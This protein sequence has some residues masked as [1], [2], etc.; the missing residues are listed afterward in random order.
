MSLRRKSITQHF[1]KI[2]NK[3][4]MTNK[5]FWKTVKP[6]LTNKGCLKN[7]DIILL[8]GE[9]MITND[10]ILAKRFNEHYINIVERSSG[11]KPS[12]MSFSVESRNNYFLRS[13]A[14]QY[15]DH[16]SII[17]IRQNALNNTHMDTSF[18]STD[19]VTPDKVNSIIKFLDASKAS[20]TD[21]I[22]MKLIIL[23]SD[24]LSK[25]ISKSLNNCITSCTFPEN[26]KVATVVPID[27]KTDD[28]YV[29]SN[30]RPV[31]LLN[32][33]SKIDEIHLKNHLVSSMNQHISNLVSAYRK[34]YSS[35]HVLIRLLEEWRKCL[36][37]NY[38][39]GGVLMD[40]SKAF[41]CVPH[42]L[43]IAKL[44]AYGIKE[45]LLAYLHSYLSNRKQCIPINN[46][47]SDFETIISAVP[48]DSIVGP[49]L[50]NCFFND[51]FYFIEK[52]SFHNFADDNTLS[53]FEETIQNLI[54]LLETES[55]T[56]IEWFQ[57]NKMMVNPGK[58]Q[59]III[60]KKKKCH[61]NE[62][63]KI[64]DK[65]IKAS[66]SVKL[67]G[68]H[69]DDQLNF[70]LHISNICRSAAN[71]LNALTSLKSFLAFEEK[72]TLINSYFY[73]NFNYCP[74][75]WMFSSAKSLNKVEFLQKRALRLLYDNYD[76][77]YESL[78]KLAEKSTMN[79]TGL[80]SLC[81]DIFKTLNNI[82]PVFMNEIFEL[83][84]TKR[85]VRN[86]YKLNLEVPIINQVT[87]GAKSI[88]Y[89]GQKSSEV[90]VK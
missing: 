45:S 3:G 44:E 41:D 18:F 68:V 26:A 53:M 67:L 47:A 86:Q 74:L 9:E 82:N 12:K 39:V 65:I 19:E 62:T 31:S 27:K 71:Q 11:F 28:K 6:F 29:I 63:S 66:S 73:S 7:N 34:N 15:K 48:Q 8:D 46:V 1:S 17:N 37:N 38:V 76:S 80:R 51:F 79:V 81:T 54:A 85:A 52:A 32:G 87:F 56:A 36:D 25:P 40:L 33:F 30:Y 61:T 22:P 21:K 5:Q 88:R 78:L 16:P 23:A 35:Q 2:T 77:S 59:T 57:N 58:F 14:N 72:K 42:D 20:G 49:I 60:D 24:F 4:I 55:N 50:F 10:R 43:L 75:V 13:I 70:N 69:I 84:K 64:G 89:L 83:R 90:K